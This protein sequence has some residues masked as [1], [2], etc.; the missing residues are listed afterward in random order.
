MSVLKK[1][2]RNFHVN[3]DEQVSILIF[4]KMCSWVFHSIRH[5]VLSNEIYTI[6]VRKLTL[7]KL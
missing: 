4:T 2:M 3:T 1:K 6:S 5:K 7:F